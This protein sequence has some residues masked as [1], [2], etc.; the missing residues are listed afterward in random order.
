MSDSLEYRTSINLHI[1]SLPL[2]YFSVISTLS[3]SLLSK[4]MEVSRLE[5][6]DFA[7]LFAI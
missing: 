5:I 3:L 7:S 1:S 2:F 6:Q 4:L